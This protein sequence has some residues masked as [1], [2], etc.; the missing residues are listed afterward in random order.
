[1]R[2]FPWQISYAKELDTISG[3]SFHR[4]VFALVLFGRIYTAS[5]A[6]VKLDDSLIRDEGGQQ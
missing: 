2:R 6:V 4:H 3:I 5:F 1:M